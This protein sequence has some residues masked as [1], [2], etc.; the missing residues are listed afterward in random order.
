MAV[1]PMIAM[2]SWVRLT[3]TV[4]S[5]SPHENFGRPQSGYLPSGFLVVP[6]SVPLTMNVQT[7]PWLQ[8]KH[9]AILLLVS[10]AIMAP[11]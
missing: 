4:A 3:V 6:Y 7:R 9:A 11:K 10:P 5:T 8:N 1:L 2:L